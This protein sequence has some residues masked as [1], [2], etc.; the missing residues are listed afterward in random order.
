MCYSLDDLDGL[1]NGWIKW[2]TSET[3]LE[4]WLD[5]IRTG[6]V[7]TE[8]SGLCLHDVHMHKNDLRVLLPS[9]PGQ[10]I[11]AVEMFNSLL[12]AIEARLPETLAD[13]RDVVLCY[14]G[15]LTA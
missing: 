13:S 8:P 3:V 12:A 10:V 2:H 4:A 5:M 6:K 1:D 11:E 15:D 7:F 9:P 14:Y